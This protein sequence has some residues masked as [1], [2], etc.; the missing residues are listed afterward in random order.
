MTTEEAMKILDPATALW[1]IEYYT[2]FKGKEAKIAAVEEA[3]RMAVEDMRKQIVMNQDEYKWH[4][5][6]Q[7]PDELPDKSMFFK[8]LL[9]LDRHGNYMTDC[10]L[11]WDF[12]NEW[13]ESES[14]GVIINDVIAWKKI[15]PF[16][17][18]D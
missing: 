2:G 10:N 18:E 8:S 17:T 12:E 7:N 13:F 1:A 11:Y 5:L 6:R 4:D 3:C 9:C 14:D 15:E 16:E